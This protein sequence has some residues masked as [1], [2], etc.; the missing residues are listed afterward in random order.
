METETG[1]MMPGLMRSSSAWT[2][3]QEWREKEARMAEE[4]KRDMPYG[5]PILFTDEIFETILGKLTVCPTGEL[6]TRV[7]RQHIGMGLC[8]HD[9]FFLMFFESAKTKPIVIGMMKELFSQMKVSEIKN[10]NLTPEN[11]Q[12]L[13]RAMKSQYKS[14]LPIPAWEMLVLALE[15]YMLLGLLFTKE[16]QADVLSQ[17]V[18]VSRLKNRRPSIQEMKFNYIHDLLK[19]GLF[20]GCES[21]LSKY[22]IISF[23]NSMRDVVKELSN[24]TIDLEASTNDIHPEKVVGYYFAIQAKTEEEVRSILSSSLYRSYHYL[25]PGANLE[26]AS[27]FF[28]DAHIISLFPCNGAWFLYDNEVGVAQ[29]TEEQTAAVNLSGIDKMQMISSATHFRYRFVLYD[30]SEFSV[31]QE[32]SSEDVEGEKVIRATT[33]KSASFRM[34]NLGTE[35]GGRKKRRRTLRKKR[36]QRTQRRRQTKSSSRSRN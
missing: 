29:L 3:D 28:G 25:A 26:S 13:A 19:Y 8:W 36:V 6:A 33:I 1:M 30:G 2:A 10:L 5:T 27:E 4:E 16:S 20:S 32:R 23:M 18:R 31:L 12:G 17:A 9:A 21:G 11:V 7:F 15:R 24:N 35:G 22:S 14:S 34:V